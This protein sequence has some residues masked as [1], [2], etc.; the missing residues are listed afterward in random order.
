MASSA[1][2]SS[3][4]ASPGRTAVTSMGHDVQ[5]HPMGLGTS[6]KAQ[7]P[8]FRVIRIKSFLCDFKAFAFPFSSSRMYFFPQVF[9]CLASSQNLLKEALPDQS[10]F[11]VHLIPSPDLISLGPNCFL[12]DFICLVEV[13]YLIIRPVTKTEDH[14]Q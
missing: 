1:S 2:P 6:L 8:L 11:W 3:W 4:A 14:T 5:S 10:F 12:K 7:G 13:L 9:T